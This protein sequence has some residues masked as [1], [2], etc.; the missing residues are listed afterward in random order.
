[1]TDAAGTC[2]KAGV[3]LPA[4]LTVD[5]IDESLRATL[6]EGGHQLNLECTICYLEVDQVIDIPCE[7]IFCTNCW[8][9]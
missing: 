3:E 9:Q 6:L 2:D 1:M 5:N 4:M 7:H 8:Q